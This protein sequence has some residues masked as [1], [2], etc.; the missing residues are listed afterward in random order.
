[1]PLFSYGRRSDARSSPPPSG[2]GDAN[3]SSS[4]RRIESGKKSSSKQ[5]KEDQRLARR[6]FQIQDRS[7]TAL[8]IL[9]V[10]GI[11]LTIINISFACVYAWIF[12]NQY[13]YTKDDWQRCLVYP[14]QAVDPLG[15]STAD[16]TN[17]LMA[18]ASYA[19]RVFVFII[20]VFKMAYVG[21]KDTDILP[22]SLF[23]NVMAILG[24]I[25]YREAEPIQPQP[26]QLSATLLTLVK[27]IQPNMY[28]FPAAAKWAPASCSLAYALNKW[29]LIFQIL[30]VVLMCSIFLVIS[31]CAVANYRIGKRWRFQLEANGYPLGLLV[32]AFVG[33]VTCFYAKETVAQLTL[34]VLNESKLNSIFAFSKGELDIVSLTMMMTLGA[35]GVG[36]CKGDLEKFKLGAFIS[37]IHVVLSYPSVL[38]TIH[39][40]NSVTYPYNK[41]KSLAQAFSIWSLDPAYGCPAYVTAKSAIFERFPKVSKR[42]EGRSER[43]KEKRKGVDDRVRV[44]QG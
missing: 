43:N 14:N 11:P 15:G 37:Y 17:Y 24:I 16:K 9:F 1:M 26:Q 40:Y 35:I 34:D 18:A 21:V 13:S 33:Y 6:Y 30:V 20:V 23:A 12:A 4:K 42:K 38:A 29:F 39:A 10:V 5:T 7:L 27:Y 22:Y 31:T 3:S 32:I 19:G 41:D 36:T 25:V 28:S 44:E 8:R 2:A